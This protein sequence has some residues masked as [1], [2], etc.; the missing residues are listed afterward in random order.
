[1]SLLRRI[2]FIRRKWGIETSVG[3]LRR[4]YKRNKVVYRR[5]YYTLRG[6][7]KDQEELMKSRK[8]FAIKLKGIKERNDPLIYFDESM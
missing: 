8:A 7:G 2:E 6:E 4:L 5:S 3:K 1:M